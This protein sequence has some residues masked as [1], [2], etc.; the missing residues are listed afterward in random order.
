MRVGVAKEIKPQ[1]YRVALTPAGARELV[2]RGHEVV[3]EQG[4]G[5]GSQFP[6]DQYEANGARIAT[7]DE[8]WETSDLLLKVKEP[9]APE[10]PRLREGLTLFT[11]LHIAAD[12][13]LTRALADSG[14]TA[15]AYET[16]ETDDRRL[17]L[18]APMSEVAGRLAAQAG[19]HYL[20][21]PKGGRGL[22]LGGVAG[23]APGKVVVIGGGIVGYNAAVIAL[24]L[25]AQVTIL[26]RSVDRMRHLEETLHGRVSLVMSSSLQIEESVRDADVVIGAVLIPGALAPKLVTREMVRGM[27]EGSVFCD[28]AIDQGGCAETSRP[29]T[30][31]DPVYEVDG[32]IHYC[33]ANMP[34][35]VPITSTKALTNVTLPYVEAIA[36]RGLADAVARDHMLARGVNVIGGKVTYEAVAEAHGLEYTPLDA[37]LAAPV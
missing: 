31:D 33:V 34:G 36:D 29:T 7:V 24:G 37:V 17:P 2:Q 1:E 3:I 18:L 27:K 25:G 14:I 5:A 35:A 9:I 23:V 32:V 26:E 16:V 10:Y 30:H 4:A 20:E 12:E 6:D 28:V 21:K 22:L 19:A 11:Y 15:V 8:V 13:P